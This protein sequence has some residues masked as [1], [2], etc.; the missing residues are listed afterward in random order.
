MLLGTKKRFGSMPASWRQ[1]LL[2]LSGCPP[3]TLD[4]LDH[5]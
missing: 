4:T 2:P 5:L 1:L 3:V